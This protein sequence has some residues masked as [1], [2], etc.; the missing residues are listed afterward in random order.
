MSRL[1]RVIERNQYFALAQP[2][3]NGSFQPADASI[4]LPEV[5]WTNVLSF[6]SVEDIGSVSVLNRALYNH[7]SLLPLYALVRYDRVLKEALGVPPLEPC[8]EKLFHAY[9]RYVLTH[10][11]LLQVNG[12]LAAKSAEC[13]VL[14]TEMRAVAT[15]V[16][17][18]ARR[19]RDDVVLPRLRALDFRLLEEF[20]FD[21]VDRG[22]VVFAT[23]PPK[24]F[25]HG[26]K[27]RRLFR[28]E[29]TDPT[30]CT[31]QMGLMLNEA[32]TLRDDLA[33]AKNTIGR[34]LRRIES[35][36][37]W[38]LH[39]LM[40]ELRECPLVNG[41]CNGHPLSVLTRDVETILD[42][43]EMESI[44]LRFILKA[45]FGVPVA[46]A[47]ACILKELRVAVAAK[48]P[49]LCVEL[50]RGLKSAPLSSHGDFHNW[51]TY[52][53]RV[54]NSRCVDAGVMMRVV[55]AMNSA[56][57]V[58]E[59]L[60]IRYSECCGKKG[61]T[62]SE[63][64]HFNCLEAVGISCTSMQSLSSV[65]CH[66]GSWPSVTIAW[67]KSGCSTPATDGN[68]GSANAIA[69]SVGVARIPIVMLKHCS[70]ASVGVYD[71]L[72]TLSML[73]HGER[74]VMHLLRTHGL[75][76]GKCAPCGRSVP[77]REPYI[78]STCYSHLIGGGRHHCQTGLT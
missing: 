38:K 65:T 23:L 58:E 34:M 76:T 67:V 77:N 14:L 70:R 19:E 74:D 53:S 10:Q 64:L 48:L 1:T 18:V 45:E 33:N 54:V 39:P 57:H 28:R 43:I 9:S 72:C 17:T 40:E 36:L 27:H 61:D 62:L 59:G 46:V 25:C 56:Q 29:F 68:R 26:S 73:M 12:N 37:L 11:R 66:Y 4:R 24:A 7:V 30:T 78:G 50:M 13:S 3:L 44:F 75:M 55:L 63:L 6:L 21:V 41:Q 51:Q 49:G 16:D 22:G 2:S 32:S 47:V 15:T 31:G 52:L 35:K 5:L 42:S 71:S 20:G 69:K 60:L 8:W